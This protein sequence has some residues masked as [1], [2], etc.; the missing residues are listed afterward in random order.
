[1]PF[2]PLGQ[3]K[4][5]PLILDGDKEAIRAKQRDRDAAAVQA[6]IGATPSASGYR[7]A[8]HPQ[9][10]GLVR[11]PDVPFTGA[12]STWRPPSA[13]PDGPAK[14]RD[15]EHAEHGALWEASHSM[16][17]ARSSPQLRSSTMNAMESC[18]PLARERE[19]W[20]KLAHR[21]QTCDLKDV[22]FPPPR[23]APSPEPAKVGPNRQ[24]LVM[25]PKYMLLHNCH[26][27]QTDLQRF[28]REQA[29]E[30]ARYAQEAEAT[31]SL[32]ESQLDVEESRST[33]RGPTRF[34]AS[35][36]AP[37]L[38][39]QSTGGPHWAGSGLPAGRGMRTSNPFRM[40]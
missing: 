25:F 22:D 15:R 17:K 32:G 4:P 21:T 5:I 34:D 20:E 10:F 19:R 1:M 29:E 33:I 2:I 7:F 9:T 6:H 18:H 28:Q 14:H 16:R 39:Q 24:G 26:L 40:G 13:D 3:R 38:R 8:N 35:W 31:M 36:G 23:Q 37:R 11:G 12:T 30:A 27:K